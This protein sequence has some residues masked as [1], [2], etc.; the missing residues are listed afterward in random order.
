MTTL[1]EL[2]TVVK[3]QVQAEPIA[4][5]D[6]NALLEIVADILR[7]YPAQMISHDLV[8]IRGQETSKRALEVAATGGHNLLLYG[9][10]GAGKSL[11]AHALVSLL[12]PAI[13]SVPVRIPCNKDALLG[14]LP[15][16]GDIAL[17]HGG[18][19]LLEHMESFEQ[20]ALAVVRQAVETGVR[21][22][23]GVSYAAQFQLIATATPCP[24]GF[25]GDPL[26][27][28][29]CT[30]EEIQNYQ[31]PMQEM[32]PCFDII[33]DVPRIHDD[34][35]K[36]RRGQR[37]EDIRMWVE[38][39]RQ[40][41]RQRYAEASSAQLNA[42]LY[43]ISEIERYCT[44]DKAAE[45]LLEAARRQLRLSP[46]QIMSMLRVARSCADLAGDETIGANHV[47]EAIQYRPRFLEMPH[48]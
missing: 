25:Y 41:Q 16:P 3:G 13:V 21:V 34:V 24:C 48:E 36:M 37:S 28:C 11:L 23:D 44:L 20:E 30:F 31:K 1:R 26:L 39:A 40:Q 38:R 8:E 4:S 17:A 42:D 29:T 6:Y 7:L 32:I 35:L 19:L 46:S 18:V 22:I 43:V 2:L 14:A 12:P 5:E 33:T 27:E 9:A 15:F 47:A 10:H 45:K